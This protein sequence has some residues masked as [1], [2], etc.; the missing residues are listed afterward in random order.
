MQEHPISMN[1]L[2]ANLIRK[3]LMRYEKAPLAGAF[4]MFD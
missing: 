1:V 3:I 2:S 4:L